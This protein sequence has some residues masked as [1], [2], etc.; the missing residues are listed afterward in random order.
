VTIEVRI[1]RAGDENVL[2]RVAEGVFDHPIDVALSAEFLRD[3]RHHLSVG[4]E[5]GVVVGFASAV[6][7]VHPDKPAEFWINEVGVA[8]S[9]QRQGIAR[10]VLS[11]LLSHGRELGCREAWVLTDEANNAAR[12]LYRSVGGTETHHIMVSFQLSQP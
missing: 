1:L 2:S 3:P 11:A 9:H 6:H 4:L 12:A 8:P 7:Y 5:D 10:L